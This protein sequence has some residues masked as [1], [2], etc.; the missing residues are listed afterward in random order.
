MTI[1]SVRTL[2]TTRQLPSPPADDL[3]PSSPR[4]CD[5][6]D[7]PFK[8]WQPPQPEGYRQSAA[9]SIETA[10]VIDNGSSTVKAGF[11]FDKVPRFMVPPIM[12]R[13][14]DRKNNKAC[15]FVGHD[16]Y[17]D[18]TTRGQIRSAFEPGTSI[19]TNWDVMEGVLDY[20]FIKL[21]VDE[22]G[23]IGRPVVMTEPMANLGYSR[24][25]MNEV[26]FECYSAPSVTYGID[27]LFSYR[28]NRGASGLVISSSHTATHLVPV[29]AGKPLYQSCARLNWGGSQAQEFLLKLLRLKY[30]TFP[31]KM[32]IEQMEEYVR[33]YCY[34]SQDYDEELSHYLDWSGLEEERDIIIQYPYTE[35][36][37]PEKSTEELVRIAERKKESGRRLQEQAAKMRLD[38]LIKK[39]QEMEYYKQLHMNYVNAP[40]KKEQRRLLDADDFKDE[41][42]LERVIREL[43]KKIRKSRNKD[44]GAADEEE[45]MEQQTF[46][47]LDVPDEE[48]DEQGIKDKR[49]QRLLK[50]GVEARL[51]AKAEKERER[52]RVAE[53][54]RLDLEKRENNFDDWIAGRRVARDI[55][56]S[57]I[58]D[59]ERLKQ[60]AGNRKSLA[61]QMR[62]KT[63]ANLA[64]DGPKRKRRGG[65]EYDDDFGANDEDW[66][67]YRTVATE[68]ASDEEE[69]E[70]PAAAL[71][72]LEAELLRYDPD[73]TEKET[74]DAQNDWTKSLI[75]AFLRG[76]RPFDPESQK[77]AHQIHLNVERIRVPEVI[78]QPGIAGV[79]QAGLAEIAEGI[80]MGR[81]N[82]A[83]Q[84]AL[85]R[86]VFVTGGNTLFKGFEDRLRRELRG[87]VDASLMINVRRASDPVLDAWKGAAGW[88]SKSALSERNAATITRDEYLEKGSEYFRE[89]SLGNSIAPAASSGS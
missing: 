24:R 82:P 12:A 1:K 68:P 8:G 52:A 83:E 6:P 2:A 34:I 80:V 89:H 44:L 49:H 87:V 47:L 29:L 59:R 43:E 72:S 77:E 56:L 63:L 66:G 88:W 85:L 23:G 31:G 7:Y 74:F 14:R 48:L 3:R 67:V 32:N 5:A 53:E 73:F 35:H 4:V 58:K 78:F 65:G 22:E 41:A 51:R 28:H 30:P 19:V 60:D 37:A 71:R 62:M 10:F 79:D 45:G 13:Y 81:T 36:I 16:A 57:K 55:L 11:S 75:H 76:A 21:G 64:S 26:V 20:V 46:P 33:R 9:T 70:D 86:D 50:S 39:E 15:T 42:A 69:E 38:K 27:S 40:T 18:A 61:S 17:A 25:M 54:E 84:Q